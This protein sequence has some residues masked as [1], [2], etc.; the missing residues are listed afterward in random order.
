[1][2]NRQVSLKV[3]NPP[4]PTGH[5]L[6]APPVLMAS[7]NSLDYSCGNCGAI[8]LHASHDQVY[9]LVIRCRECGSYSVTE[10]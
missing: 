10:T 4:P 8:V 3:I 1:M 6:D 5:V 7:D 9:G 2:P